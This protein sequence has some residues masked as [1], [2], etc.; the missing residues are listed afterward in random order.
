MTGLLWSIGLAAIGIAGLWLAGAQKRIGWAIGLT[1]QLLWATYGITTGQW[2]FLASAAAYGAVYAR[3]LARGR[4]P[5]PLQVRVRAGLADVVDHVVRNAHRT[6]SI[7]AR[8]RLIH[9]DWT[10]AQVR[11]EA[12]AIRATWSPS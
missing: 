11:A 9:P 10:R 4:S 7:E 1:A 5:V 12:R 6:P 2:G 3:N 8:I